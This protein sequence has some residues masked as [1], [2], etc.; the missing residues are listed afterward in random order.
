MAQS[1]KKLEGIQALWTACASTHKDSSSPVV[2]DFEGIN[3]VISLPTGINVRKIS[4]YL[5]DSS[6]WML[7]NQP[8]CN[9]SLSDF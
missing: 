3:F 7:N 1:G 6:P 4:S 9:K 5:K 8:G 2:W